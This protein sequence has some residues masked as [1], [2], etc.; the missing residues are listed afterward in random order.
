MAAI[1][2]VVWSSIVMSLLSGL[3]W[4]EIGRVCRVRATD[5]RSWLL[6]TVAIM[7]IR[8]VHYYLLLMNWNALASWAIH[9]SLLL[10]MLS[11]LAVHLAM[12]DLRRH[13]L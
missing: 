11:T 12:W 5:R 4:L 2:V 13:L 7:P 6:N 1:V 3:L 9:H 10:D 8:W